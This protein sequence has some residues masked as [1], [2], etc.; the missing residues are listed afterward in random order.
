MD[1]GKFLSMDGY[2]KTTRQIGSDQ[3]KIPFDDNKKLSEEDRNNA[4]AAAM[5]KHGKPSIAAMG[6]VL[7]DTGMKNC[8]RIR[9]NCPKTWELYTGLAEVD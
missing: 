7:L 8:D 3:M 6:Q 4:V 1:R 5:V 2:P 9:K